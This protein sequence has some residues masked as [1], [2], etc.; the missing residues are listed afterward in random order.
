MTTIALV[1]I[2]EEIAGL[3][4]LLSDLSLFEGFS[5]LAVN[6]PIR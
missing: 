1:I 5:F 3:I 2:V 6:P 4:A